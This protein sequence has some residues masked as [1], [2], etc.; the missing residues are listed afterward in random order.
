MILKSLHFDQGPSRL[1]HLQYL[2]K[3]VRFFFFSV[4]H[5][6]LVVVPVLKMRPMVEA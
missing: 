3:L 1:V 6:L 2:Q 4:H 5:D